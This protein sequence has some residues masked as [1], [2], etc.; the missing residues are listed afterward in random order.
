MTEQVS[1]FTLKTMIGTTEIIVIGGVVLLL[2]G[3]TA[4]PKFFRSLGKA[5]SEFEKGV[6]EIDSDKE[7]DQDSK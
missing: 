2:F 3:A 4:L 7:P 1:R 6:K 5:K